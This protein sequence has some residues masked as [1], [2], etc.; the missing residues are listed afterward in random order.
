VGKQFIP[1]SITGDGAGFA[2]GGSV[3]D[4]NVGQGEPYTLG[5]YEVSIYE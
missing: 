1:P 4:H 3:L 5:V 2:A